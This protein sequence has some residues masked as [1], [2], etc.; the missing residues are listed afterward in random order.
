MVVD[1]DRRHE[2]DL[3]AEG[4]LGVKVR[5]YLGD[6][7]VVL[8]APED[9]APAARLGPLPVDA[10]G[11]TLP[12]AQ[13]ETVLEL[14]SHRARLVDDGSV[15]AEQEGPFAGIGLVQECLSEEPAFGKPDLPVV[16]APTIHLAGA[17][18]GH[19]YPAADR[20]RPAVDDQIAAVAKTEVHAGVR[21]VPLDGVVPAYDFQGIDVFP[22]V[23]PRVLAGE[24]EAE[25][26]GNRVS[27]SELTV[28]ERTFSTSQRDRGARPVD[29][30]GRDHVHDPVRRVGSI[31][32]R[33]RPQRDFD[34][35]DVEV[36]R[37]E[38]RVRIE[39]QRRDAG[40]PV[41]DDCE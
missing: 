34:P 26:V 14:Q 15:G 17:D 19:L 7:V 29:R 1:A 30:R 3:V 39:P 41:V 10:V 22:I 23:T 38:H 32:G 40:V 18:A 5:P 27:A 35:V 36:V 16:V 13:V 28:E 12:G 11:E 24:L 20:R 8:V 31:E 25:A 21:A 37:R 2:V 33:A 4:G 9:R 6:D